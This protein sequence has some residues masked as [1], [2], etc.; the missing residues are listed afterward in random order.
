MNPVLREEGPQ[1]VLDGLLRIII[2]SLSARRGTSIKQRF[3]VRAPKDRRHGGL[4]GELQLV[5]SQVLTA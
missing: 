2:P 5:D 1:I 4:G 3:D